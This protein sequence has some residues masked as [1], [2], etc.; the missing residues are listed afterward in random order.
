M[1]GTW[2]LPDFSINEWNSYVEIKGQEPSSKE[3]EK[4]KRLNEGSNRTV[5]LIYGQ[6]YPKE[7]KVVAYD[8][9]TLCEDGQFLQCRKCDGIWVTGDYSGLSLDQKARSCDKCPDKYPV[10]SDQIQEAFTRIRA[11]RFS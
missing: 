8:G 9:E 7:Y 3:V 4:C 6:P 5:L 2:Y 10:L 1:D 11:F